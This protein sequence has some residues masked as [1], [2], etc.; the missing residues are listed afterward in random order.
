MRLFQ[1]PGFHF[2]CWSLGLAQARTQTT[3]TERACLYRHARAR[4]CLV[5]IGTWHGV[6]AREMRRVMDTSRTL[7]AIDMFP[8]N[9]WGFSWERRIAHG[10]VARVKNGRVVFFET[11]SLDAAPRFVESGAPPIDLCFID[12]DHSYEGLRADWEAWTP[13]MS[14]GGIVALHDSRSCQARDIKFAG[15]VKFTQE[16]AIR[17][18]RFIVIETADTLTVLRK[19]RE[20]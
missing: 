15:S 1:S 18:N 16:R 19:E 3:A 17:D 6:N 10:E 7:F 9:R 8:A 12:G 2:V 20:G 11:R 14:I 5:E 4:K 13:L